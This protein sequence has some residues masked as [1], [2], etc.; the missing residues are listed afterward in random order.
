MMTESPARASL[1]E[2][3]KLG[4]MH[5]GGKSGVELHPVI[6]AGTSTAQNPRNANCDG[7]LNTR[8]IPMLRQ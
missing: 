5:G 2:V 8:K 3:E 4:G 7:F 6:V 1:T